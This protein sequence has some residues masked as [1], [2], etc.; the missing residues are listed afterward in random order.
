MKPVSFKKEWKKIY[1][2]VY[3]NRP[4]NTYT[5]ANIKAREFLLYAQVSLAKAEEAYE[6]GI[7]KDFDFYFTLYLAIWKY[8]SLSIL[9][10]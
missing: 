3:R 10:K 8:Y 7:Q 1:F 2:E 5:K 4:S 9:S 6:N